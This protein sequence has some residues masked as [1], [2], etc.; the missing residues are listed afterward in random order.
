MILFSSDAFYIFNFFLKERR[1]RRRMCGDKVKA[2]QFIAR[3]RMPA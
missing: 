2:V 1:R 3:A